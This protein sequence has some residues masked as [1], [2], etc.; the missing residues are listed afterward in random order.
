MLT[1]ASSA[2]SSAAV[3]ERRGIRIQLCGAL[4]AEFA[5]HRVDRLLA[6]RKGGTSSPAL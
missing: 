5:G 4:V 6:G 3:L 1:Q 2:V